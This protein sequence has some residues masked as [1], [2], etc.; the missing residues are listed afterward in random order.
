M[1]K[2][3]YNE[4]INESLLGKGIKI[5]IKAFNDQKTEYEQ[6]ISLLN[7]E[8][9]KLKEENFLYKNKLSSLQKKLNSLSKTVLLLNE[10]TDQSKNEEEKN[11]TE[12]MNNNNKSKSKKNDNI[13]SRNNRF[14]INKNL[15]TKNIKMNSTNSKNNINNINTIY[16]KHKT[17]Y[18]NNLKNLKYTINYQEKNTTNKNIYNL[19]N[20]EIKNFNENF[21]N[22]SEISLNNNT[23]NNLKGNKDMEISGDNN[24]EIYKKLNLF[25]QECKTVLNELEYEGVLQLLKSFEKNSDVDIRKKIKKIIKNKK[26]LTDLF[27]DI[28]E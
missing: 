24:S 28:F 27:D 7:T 26:K 25:L 16:N 14:S 2:N 23:T 20:N 21:S 8:I 6:N 12:F 4:K 9:K 11:I 5:I 15:S 13:I 22:M 1:P 3:V 18:A 10:E 19:N 17:T